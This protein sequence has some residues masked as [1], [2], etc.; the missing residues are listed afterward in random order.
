[1][2]PEIPNRIILGFRG[3]AFNLGGRR[4]SFHRWSTHVVTGTHLLAPVV[5]KT[6]CWDRGGYLVTNSA[7]LHK[8]DFPEI[9]SWSLG[10]GECVDVHR[11]TA[12]RLPNRHRICVSGRVEVDVWCFRNPSSDTIDL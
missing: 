10:H 2:P 12:L 6:R 7:G 9:L 5:R 4:N 1:C 11:R 3:K 8:R